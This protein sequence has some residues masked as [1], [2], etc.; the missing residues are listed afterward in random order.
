M[1][2]E[3]QLLLENIELQKR[4]SRMIEIRS[5]EMVKTSLD[6]F[7]IKTE[8]NSIKNRRI[9]KLLKFLKVWQ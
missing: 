9:Y 8:L 1:G 3:K 6:L 5:S 2:K 7:Y 4:I